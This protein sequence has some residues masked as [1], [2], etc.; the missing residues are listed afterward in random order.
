MT[1]KAAVYYWCIP[2]GATQWERPAPRHPLTTQE[3]SGL[4]NG[5]PA[6]A[7][8]DQR[9]G[10]VSPRSDSTTS[11]SSLETLPLYGHSNLPSCG[12]INSYYF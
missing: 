10:C 9:K 4:G 7:P 8:D 5:S 6:L 1:D 12:F 2:S 3:G 11:D